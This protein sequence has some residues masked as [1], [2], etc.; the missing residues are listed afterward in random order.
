MK[1]GL[2]VIAIFI[3]VF[4]TAEVSAAN[5]GPSRIVETND[6][7]AAILLWRS[8]ANYGD[9]AAEFNL[10]QAYLLGTGVNADARQA[11]AWFRAS[12]DNGYSAAQYS[13]ATLL[14]E[15][16]GVAKDE[17]EGVLYLEKAAAQAHPVAL[18]KLGQI[19]KTGRIVVA[20]LPKARS[21]LT[22][23]AQAGYGPAQYEVGIMYYTGKG[24]ERDFVLARSW[25]ELASLSANPSQKLALGA[26]KA[27]EQKMTPAQISESRE[28]ARKCMLGGVINCK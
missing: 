8:L 14:F 18:F 22:A 1:R 24:A 26:V 27:A 9:A 4:C 2:V 5:D 11:A 19:Y 6:F 28:V 15:G 7:A 25:L 12:A 17:K 10:G 13:L 16:S 21:L 20:D 3:T 23:S